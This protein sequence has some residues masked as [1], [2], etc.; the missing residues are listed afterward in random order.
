[1][2]HWGPGKR[3]LDTQAA[4]GPPEGHSGDAQV[5]P[6]LVWVIAFL[7]GAGQDWGLS[8]LKEPLLQATPGRWLPAAA[9]IVGCVV[10]GT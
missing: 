2:T 5:S 10:A 8:S 9:S 4:C 7:T 3:F 1:M 6:L